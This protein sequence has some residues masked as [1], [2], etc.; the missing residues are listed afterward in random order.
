MKHDYPEFNERDKARV[1]GKE[2]GKRSRPPSVVNGNT[3]NKLIRELRKEGWTLRKIGNLVGLT[4]Q[5]IQQI[6]AGQE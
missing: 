3:R 6:C 2:P 4:P 5:R 1:L